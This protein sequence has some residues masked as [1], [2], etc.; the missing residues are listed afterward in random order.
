[1]N[2]NSKKLFIKL[3][4][5]VFPIIVLILIFSWGYIT[6]PFFDKFDQ[7][8]FNTLETQM[9]NLFQDLNTASNGIDK[10]NYSFFCSVNRTGWMKTGNYTCTSSTLVQKNVKSVSEV[11]EMNSTYQSVIAKSGILTQL[12]E[13]KSES[14]NIFGNDFVVS[15]I[16]KHYSEKKSKIECDY[17]IKLYQSDRGLGLNSDSYGTAILNGQGRVLISLRCSDTARDHWYPL[18]DTTDPTIF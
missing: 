2:K 17:L 4:I 15:S 10:W 7:N 11:N 5:F 6:S 13:S 18:S 16:E 14:S 1:M 3:L 8:R 12:K 9:Q